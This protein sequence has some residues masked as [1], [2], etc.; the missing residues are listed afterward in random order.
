MR[1]GA[2]RHGRRNAARCGST[3]RRVSTPRRGRASRRPGRS[4][5]TLRADYSS[6]ACGPC[7][8]CHSRRTA[9]ASRANRPFHSR[10]PSRSLRSRRPRSS[11]RI[12]R[13]SGIR[14]GRQGLPRAKRRK[15]IHPVVEPDSQQQIRRRKRLCP[16]RI[17]ENPRAY[18]RQAP[19]VTLLHRSS[20]SVH[21][22]C[23]EC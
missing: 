13:I 12:L 8:T 1:V 3:I 11:G 14:R 5:R 21:R 7:R 6:G 4:N 2:R 9:R 10:R 20:P 16:R 17:L 15:A 19:P 22:A 18:R 23:V